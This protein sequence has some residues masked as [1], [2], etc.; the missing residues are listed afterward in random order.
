MT[1]SQFNF[2]YIELKE[3]KVQ[4]FILLLLSRTPFIYPSPYMI[5][6]CIY[7]AD[8]LVLQVVRS[9][10]GMQYFIQIFH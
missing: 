8:H 2:G 3:L 9:S 10:Q 5:K 1:K 7:S 4:L 6:L